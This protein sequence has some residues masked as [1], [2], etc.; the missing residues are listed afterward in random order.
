M[1]GRKTGG[2]SRKGR[3]NAEDRPR[4]LQSRLWQVMRIRRRF[5][6][7]DL[8]AEARLGEE[9]IRRG[10]V[11]TYVRALALTGYL[12]LEGTQHTGAVRHNVYVLARDTGPKAPRPQ[13]WVLVRVYDPNEDATYEP[14]HEAALEVAGGA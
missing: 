11:Q 7:A 12:R 3:P 6:T 14:A 1:L 5:T 8:E 10:S 2:G 13:Q 9:A 4:S